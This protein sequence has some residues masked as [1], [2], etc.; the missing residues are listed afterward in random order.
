MRK[1]DKV[2]LIAFSFSISPTF[3]HCF[4]NHDRTKEITSRNVGCSDYVIIHTQKRRSARGDCAD[5][6]GG[7]VKVVRSLS[8]E[9]K[10]I[11]YKKKKIVSEANKWWCWKKNEARMWKRKRDEAIGM[12]IIGPE[13]DGEVR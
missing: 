10:K 3:R 8:V 5:F 13:E 4:T 12:A 6:E 7:R 1:F 9:K 11:H 2:F